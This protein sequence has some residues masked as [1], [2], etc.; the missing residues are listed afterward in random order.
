MTGSR[1]FGDQSLSRGLWR[2]ENAAA[3]LG[4][5]PALGDWLVE[6]HVSEGMVQATEAYRQ[7]YSVNVVI[8]SFVVG[9]AIDARR[10]KRDSERKRDGPAEQAVSSRGNTAVTLAHL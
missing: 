10:R 1:L 4:R 3:C 2:G 6:T 5:V 8:A 7:L 9:L